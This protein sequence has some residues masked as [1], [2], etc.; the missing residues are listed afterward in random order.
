MVCMSKMQKNSMAISKRL[1]AYPYF[2]IKFAYRT[3]TNNQA[4]KPKKKIKA[5]PGIKTI[6]PKIKSFIGLSHHKICQVIMPTR[7]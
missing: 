1:P 6:P 4:K 3:L 2:M 7:L 5:M